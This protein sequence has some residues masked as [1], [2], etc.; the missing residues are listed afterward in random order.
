MKIRQNFRALSF[1][2]LAMTVGAV[3]D[4]LAGKEVMVTGYNWTE[5]VDAG[6]KGFL[7]G[8]GTMVEIEAE[9]QAKNPP[10]GKS[11]IPTLHEG[12]SKLTYTQL[13]EAVD[14]YYAEHP[15]DLGK[16]VIHVIWDVAKDNL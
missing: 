10:K 5:A 2:L 16:P 7:I 13:Q 11:A 12:L 3:S 8:L 9:F 1:L 14:N 15:N 4:A 6:K